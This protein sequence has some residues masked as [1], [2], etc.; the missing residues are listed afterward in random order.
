MENCLAQVALD[1]GAQAA[2]QILQLTQQKPP[3]AFDFC[4]LASDEITRH[5]HCEGTRERGEDGQTVAVTGFCQDVTER[6][7]AEELLLSTEKLN[8]LGQLTG[9]LAHDFN[10]LLTV[11][12]VSIEIAADM[13]GT[14]HP[15]FE[16]LAPAA[17]ASASGAELVSSLLSFARR[18]RLAPERSD[19]NAVLRELI[20]LA[21]RTLGARHTLTLELQPD[22][23]DCQ[24]DRAQF[25]SAMLNLLVNSRDATASGGKITVRSETDLVSLEQ[26]RKLHDIAPGRFV[27]VTVIDTGTGIPDE[28]RQ[29]VFEP[30]FTTKKIG[31]GNGLGLSMVMGFVRQSGGQI[32][33]SSKLGQGT[34]VRL[35]FP[36]APEP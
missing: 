6:K 33:L 5:Y 21:Q 7:L 4:V 20:T 19:V 27:I 11:I 26:A 16:I 2:E 13:L 1:D 9:G 35:Y 31:K 18:K 3:V 32:E 14:H 22:L 24:L 10:N 25:E 29:K 28:I 30:F 15:V 36:I 23:P 12:S 8:S 34:T 17:R